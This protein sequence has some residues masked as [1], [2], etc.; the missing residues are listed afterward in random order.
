MINCLPISR[1]FNIPLLTLFGFLFILNSSVFSQVSNIKE[2]CIPLE[3]KFNTSQSASHF[4]DFKDG[5]TSTLQ[6]PNHVFTAPGVYEVEYKSSTNGSVLKTLSIEVYP[7][8]SFS[9]TND[10]DRG[11]QPFHYLDTLSISSDPKIEINEINITYGN[12]ASSKGDTINYIYTNSGEYNISVDIKTNYETCDQ[13]YIFNQKVIVEEVPKVKIGTDPSPPISCDSNLTVRVRNL[14]LTSDTLEYLWTYNGQTSTEKS[15]QDPIEYS[16]IGSY[17]I[18]LKAT[19]NFGCTKTDTIFAQVGIPNPIVNIPDTICYRSENPFTITNSADS[20]S[21]ELGPNLAIDSLGSGLGIETSAPGNTWIR[22]TTFNTSEGCSATTT[23]D[24]YVDDPKFDIITDSLYTCEREF[25]KTFSLSRQFPE[26]LWST[27]SSRAT[28]TTG[29]GSTFTTTFNYQRT[30]PY[31]DFVSRL[32]SVTAEATTAFGCKRTEILL[33]EHQP[34]NALL[35]PNVRVACAPDTVTFFDYSTSKTDFTNYIINFGD[36]NSYN[37][38]P[39]DSITHIYT[40]ADTFTITMIATN[41]NGCVDTS[42]PVGIDL[43]C[44]PILDADEPYKCSRNILCYGDTAI[45]TGL[46]S[47][48]SALDYQTQGLQILG[49]HNSLPLTYIVN[50][51]PRLNVEQGDPIIPDTS[52]LIDLSYYDYRDLNVNGQIRVNRGSTTYPGLDYKTSCDEPQDLLIYNKSLFGTSDSVF[53]KQYDQN[54][55]QFVDYDKS[56]IVDSLTYNNLPF[57]LYKAII[58]ST[59]P[60]LSCAPTLDSIELWITKPKADFEIPELICGGTPLN[61]NAKNSTDVNKKCSK[62]Y[63][64]KTTFE[65]DFR[66]SSDEVTITASGNDEREITLIVDDINGCTDTITHKIKVFQPMVTIN[67]NPIICNPTT[68][69]LSPTIASDTGVTEINWV[70]NGQSS[71]DSIATFTFNGPDSI[72]SLNATIKI[73]DSLG[74]EAQSSVAIPVTKVINEIQFAPN[75]LICEGEEV[76]FSSLITSPTNLPV[77]HEWFIDGTMVSTDASFTYQ[78]T[79]ANQYTVR[80]RSYIDGSLCGEEQTQVID[81]RGKP[82]L[83]FDSTLDGLPTLCAPQQVTFNNTSASGQGFVPV[84]KGPSGFFIG[85]EYSIALDRGT[86][87]ISLIGLSD[88]GYACS[89]T[90]TKSFTL[91]G[92]S[93]NINLSRDTICLGETV[94]FNLTDTID[95]ARWTWDFG[96]GNTQSNTNQIVYTY[97]RK[98]T[99][100]FFPVSATLYSANDECNIVITDTVFILNLNADFTIDNSNGLNVC[101]TDLNITNNSTLTDISFNY[102]FGDGAS[103]TDKNPSHSY[104]QPGFYNITLVA[105]TNDGLCADTITKNLNVL[106]PLEFETEATSVCPGE[107]ASIPFNSNRTIDTIT[108]NPANLV[109]GY[110]ASSIQTTPITVPPTINV[111]AQDE[112]GCTTTTVIDNITIQNSNFFAADT[113][114]IFSGNSITLNIPVNADIDIT[115]QNPELVGCTDCTNPTVNPSVT[116]VYPLTLTDK[117]GCGST[118]IYYLVN[119]FERPIV[120]NL[121]TPNNDGSN[122]TWFVMMPGDVNPTV[123]TIKI[124]DRWGAVVFETTNPR[125]QWDGKINGSPAPNGVYAYIVDLELIGGETFKSSGEVTL[126]Q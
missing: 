112:F 39:V 125:E 80:L 5:A 74:C 20:I 70:F 97:D 28:P 93:G 106:G 55:E 42:A 37:G 60:A 90:L 101:T 69:N 15:P 51:P 47:L 73:K 104:G 48:F 71:T 109:K 113:F 92:P 117:N 87:E 123:N 26:V 43:T 44:P 108:F 8:V 118:T 107:E 62:G 12:G 77:K 66:T 99:N 52:Y 59:N 83:T 38:P 79:T 24:L 57:G 56:L 36:G 98:P 2:G 65:P 124:Y 17:P 116:T 27:D 115:W 29:S 3:V 63:L 58:K 41:I 120:P 110:N 31:Q 18:T 72:Q 75:G 7:Q 21:I 64:W 53:L 49:C 95:I 46:T 86:T 76:L 11:C 94:T 54:T 89:D 9:L 4:W 1:S 68:F 10:L 35:I 105:Q 102:S 25:T 6:N 13:T 81:V 34:V 122:D 16:G 96:D 33:I 126:I 40:T 85:D 67:E 100:G 78:F 111:L 121:F 50:G 88:A 19:N 14:T 103:S 61:L 114:N 82:T 22:V 91:K 30:H 45:V 84:W 23:K 119:V 32:Y